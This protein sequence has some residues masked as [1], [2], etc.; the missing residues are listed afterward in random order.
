MLL[1]SEENA[2]TVSHLSWVAL[3]VNLIKLESCEKEKLAAGK[4]L[5]RSDWLAGMSVGD[6]LD[7]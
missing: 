5:L 7:C 2:H 1:G 6:C 3:T 4:F